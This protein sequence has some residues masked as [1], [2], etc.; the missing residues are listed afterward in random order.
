MTAS[1]AI[2][3]VAYEALLSA[4]DNYTR[5]TGYPPNVKI[6]CGDGTV[7]VHL[8]ILPENT[9]Q[10][11]VHLLEDAAMVCVHDRSPQTWSLTLLTTHLSVFIP[12]TSIPCARRTHLLSSAYSYSSTLATI[13]PQEVISQMICGPT[14][15][16]LLLQTLLVLEHSETLLSPNSKPL[17]FGTA[18]NL[19]RLL[20]L[21]FLC[22][23]LSRTFDPRS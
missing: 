8:K 6:R 19:L 21:I 14:S 22:H 17:R 5:D 18:R 16:Y 4:R 10:F 1:S 3:G 11:E 13:Q 9:K 15:Q 2:H 23:H 12:V 20:I 7:D